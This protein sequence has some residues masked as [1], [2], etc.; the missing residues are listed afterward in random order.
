M[1]EITKI[2]NSTNEGNA[3]GA[4]VSSGARLNMVCRC[5]TVFLLCLTIVRAE[6]SGTS[7]QSISMLLQVKTDA[8]QIANKVKSTKKNKTAELAKKAV[9]S[10]FVA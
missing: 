9:K 7:T 10:K 1:Q 4:A 8:P 6:R 2:I 3:A 5:A